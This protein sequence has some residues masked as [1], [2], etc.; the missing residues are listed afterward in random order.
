LN[1]YKK[2]KITLVK[3]KSQFDPIVIRQSKRYQACGANF[4]SFEILYLR[5]DLAKMIPLITQ[6]LETLEN[7]AKNTNALK[8]N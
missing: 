3:K 8:K 2:F 7:M 1:Y 5:R 4:V 6:V